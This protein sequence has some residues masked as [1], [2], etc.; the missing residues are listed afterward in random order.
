MIAHAQ[1]DRTCALHLEWHPYTEQGQGAHNWVPLE[2]QWVRSQ[3]SSSHDRQ[4]VRDD[5]PQ[6]GI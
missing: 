1:N 6:A 4:Q 2:T 5:V 3:S